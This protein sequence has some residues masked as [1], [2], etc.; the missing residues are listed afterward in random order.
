MTLLATVAFTTWFRGVPNWLRAWVP[1]L[2]LPFLYAEMPAVI[3]AAGNAQLFDPRVMQWE[4]QLFGE[5]PARTWA[6]RWTSRT[7]SELL[8]AAYLS[9]YGIIFSVPAVLWLRRRRSEFIDATFVLMLVFVTCFFIYIVFPVA[10]PRYYWSHP[11][12]VSGPL[13]RATLWILETGSSRG[14]AFPSS[15]VAVALTQSLLAIRYFGWKGASLLILSLGLGVGAIYGGFHYAIDIVA[16]A[17]L[18]LLI[19]AVGLALTQ[20]RE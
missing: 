7:L 2:T 19:F 10:G 15:H 6:M 20:K 12:A 14:T 5:Q 16:G 17:I 1:L 11:D 9:Y 8:H 3:G 13:R 4:L 18:G